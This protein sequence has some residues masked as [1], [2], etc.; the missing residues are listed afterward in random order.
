MLKMNNALFLNS[1]I[2]EC[3]KVLDLPGIGRSLHS[4]LMEI[5]VTTCGDLKQVSLHDLQS[6]FGSRTG[7]S[8][9][10]HCRGID[11]R[12]LKTSHERQSVSAEINYGIRFSEVMITLKVLMQPN[13]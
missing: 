3:Q 10:N 8:L 5:G 12:Q 7:Q 1:H 13:F 4:K 2:L 9:F 11:N 6:K